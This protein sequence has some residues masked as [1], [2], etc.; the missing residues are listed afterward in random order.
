MITRH[1]SHPRRIPGHLTV[2]QLAEKLRVATHWIHDRIHNGTIRVAKDKQTGL[3]LFPD[4]AKTLE[5]FRKLVAGK[6]HNLR[7]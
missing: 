3:Y 4:K 5:R 2:P 6:L 7:F 1:Q